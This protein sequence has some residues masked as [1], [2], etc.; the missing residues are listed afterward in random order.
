MQRPCV[1]EEVAGHP[2]V[3]LGAGYI[4]DGFTPVAAVELG[5][6]HAGGAD[7]ADGEAL[8]IGHGDDGRLAVAGVAGNAD[9]F[10]IDGFVGFEVI[11]S[12]AG[13]PG[14]GA[15]CAPVFGLAVLAFVAQT[16][17]TFA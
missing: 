7:V 1:F 9:L 8:V 14:P 15:Q 17:N 13:A 5:S 11:E 2:V 10:G 12:A 3:L 6:A 4:L 16:D